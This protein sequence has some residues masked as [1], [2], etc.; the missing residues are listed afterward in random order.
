MSQLFFL[1]FV[2]FLVE[3]GKF[4]LYVTVLP[5]SKTFSQRKF[6]FIRIMTLGH[7]YPGSYVKEEGAT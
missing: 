5:A 4:V 7:D 2:Q 6:C 3:N 1:I